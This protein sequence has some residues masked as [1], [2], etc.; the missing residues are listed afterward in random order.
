MNLDEVES[1]HVVAVEVVECWAQA[2]YN[3]SALD[4]MTILEMALTFFA[5]SRSCILCPSMFSNLAI[6]LVSETGI[7]MAKYFPSFRS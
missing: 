3:T 7:R 1:F 2:M 6:S 4:A 5:M